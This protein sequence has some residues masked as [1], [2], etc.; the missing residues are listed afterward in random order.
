MYIYDIS[1]CSSCLSCNMLQQLIWSNRSEWRRCERHHSVTRSVAFSP[2]RPCNLQHL[3][4]HHRHRDYAVPVD[5]KHSIYIYIYLKLDL[6]SISTYIYNYIIIMSV[7]KH[8]CNQVIRTSWSHQKSSSSW[9]WIL[10][11]GRDWTGVL[12]GAG[13]RTTIYF[14]WQLK[15]FEVSR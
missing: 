14:S 1:I 7:H 9:Y 5:H 11:P 4:W 8:S 10:A 12:R 6:Y 3:V 2:G 15:R 13:S